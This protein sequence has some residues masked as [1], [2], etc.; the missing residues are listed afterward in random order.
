MRKTFILLVAVLVQSFHIMME[1]ITF[2]LANTKLHNEQ[3]TC[4]I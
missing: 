2:L 4:Q 1:N 3:S